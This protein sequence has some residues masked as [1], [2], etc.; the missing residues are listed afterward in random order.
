MTLRSNDPCHCGSG[1]KYRLCCLN[2]DYD[3]QSP[4]QSDSVSVVIEWLH[5]NHRKAMSVALE[6]FL[7]EML[8]DDEIEQLHELDEAQVAGIFI[9]LN[10]WLLAEGHLLIKGKERRVSEYVLGIN[11]PSLTPGQRQW[12]MQ[13]EN[14]PLRLYDVTDVVPGQQFTACDVVDMHRNPIVVQER[15][16]TQSLRP[17]MRLGCR[18]MRVDTHFEMSGAVYPFSLLAGEAVVEQLKEI[19]QELAGEQD[20]AHEMGKEITAMWL[21]QFVTP[22]EMPTIM[23]AYSGDPIHLVTDHYHVDDWAMLERALV[24]CKDVQGDRKNGW[25]RLLQCEDG[26]SRPVVT[27]NIGAKANTVELFTK[28]LAYA[29]QARAWF[30]ALVGDS[31]R[32]LRRESVDPQQ[33][34]TTRGGPLQAEPPDIDPT[35]LSQAIGQAIQRAYANWADEPISL[36]DHK[37][38]RQAMQTPAGLERVKGLIRSYETDETEQAAQQRRPAVSYAFLWASIGLST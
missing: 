37:T 3:Q 8:S 36:L 16:G 11:G 14:N 28:T 25:D 6:N 7:Q 9:N 17:G 12:I 21:E 29:T 30:E 32:F 15:L 38:P 10:E 1:K 18:L 33:F 23:D 34:A 4:E 22:A 31:A 13:L 27:I 20:L 19:A 24:A 26:Q 2:K 5:R 35:L